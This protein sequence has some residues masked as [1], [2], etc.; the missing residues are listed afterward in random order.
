ML[1]NTAEVVAVHGLPARPRLLVGAASPAELHA[2][3]TYLTFDVTCDGHDYMYNR[4][5]VRA[6]EEI[7]GVDSA[8]CTAPLADD[9]PSGLP[10]GWPAQGATFT[11]EVPLYFEQLRLH[12]RPW[13]LDATDA[14]DASVFVGIVWDGMVS[15]EWNPPLAPLAMA[16]LQSSP[17]R[18]ANGNVV[19]PMLPL[20]VPAITAVVPAFGVVHSATMETNPATGQ[21]TRIVADVEGAHFEVYA[22][23]VECP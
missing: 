5:T 20:D 12:G 14:H 6:L 4:T 21:V 15:T 3:L 19:I 22:I 10:L 13:T 16:V 23:V 1:V 9:T 11:A 7:F 2:A 17:N 18:N 8:P